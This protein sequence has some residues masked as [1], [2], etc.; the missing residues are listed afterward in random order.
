MATAHR[1]T[2][3]QQHFGWDRGFAPAAR[4]APGESL[5]FSV[6]DASGGQ[7]GE[8]SAVGDVARLAGD[9]DSSIVNAIRHALFKYK[10]I[11]FRGQE[12]LD[13]ASHQ[14]FGRVLGDIVPHP[15]HDPQGHASE[16]GTS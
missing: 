6:S 15:T 2:I 11:F 9:L 1:H 7:L 8:T 3:H 13:E 5:E 4:I 10:V 14:A 16:R 12:H